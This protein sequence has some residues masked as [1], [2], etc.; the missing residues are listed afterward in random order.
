MI[1]FITEADVLTEVT[2]RNLYTVLIEIHQNLV[3]RDPRGI[4][5]NPVTDDIAIGYSEV[6]HLTFFFLYD[7]GYQICN[8]VLSCNRTY[9]LPHVLDVFNIYII[10]RSQLMLITI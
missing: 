7:F 4:F 9:L 10:T 3:R 1:S 8:F 2:S 6:C 5:A